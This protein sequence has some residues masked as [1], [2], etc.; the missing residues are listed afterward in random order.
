MPYISTKPSEAPKLEGLVEDWV[1]TKVVKWG[2]YTY[3]A[4]RTDTS[5]LKLIVVAFDA[6]GREVGRWEKAGYRYTKDIKVDQANQTITFIMRQDSSS[7]GSFPIT[8]NWTE[9]QVK[10]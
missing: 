2:G 1:V 8:F 4:Y 7:E 3:W 10:E 6:S 9:L 5:A